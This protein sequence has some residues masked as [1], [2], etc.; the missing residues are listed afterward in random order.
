MLEVI[1]NIF[2]ILLS[3]HSPFLSAVRLAESYETRTL[4]E[5]TGDSIATEYAH[6]V[7][8]VIGLERH[9]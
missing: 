2:D 3:I 6:A 5:R 7:A 1:K 9:A 4:G 8:E